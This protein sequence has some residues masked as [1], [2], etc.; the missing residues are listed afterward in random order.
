M[1]LGRDFECYSP[2][3]HEPEVYMSDVV[4]GASSI[5][6]LGLFAGRSFCAGQR[7]RQINVVREVTPT[8]PLREEL[9]ER[10][11]HCDYPDGKIVLLGPPDRHINHSCD[12]NAYVLYERNH[13]F[14][15]AR[16]D[17]AAGEEIA[18]DYNINITGGTAWPCHCG[19]ARCKGTTLG[20]FFR[21]PFN[22]QGEYR[23]LL[24][25][26]FVRTHLDRLKALGLG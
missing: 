13:S 18:C 26:W 19:A 4:V 5:E 10:A 25:E 9:G 20:G 21:L 15:V 7:I 24:A 22:I 11:D 12:P 6:G 17:I 2:L 14:L 3:L 16:R 23:P 8:S 1:L